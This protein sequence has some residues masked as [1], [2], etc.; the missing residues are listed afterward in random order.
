MATG[1]DRGATCSGRAA[2][3]GIDN[4]FETPVM[5]ETSEPGSVRAPG[6]RGTEIEVLVV[7]SGISGI[8]M[9]HK[10]RQ[11]GSN[12]VVFE[13]APGVGGT[14]FWNRYPGAQC[15]VPSMQY[16]YSFDEDL[17]QEWEWSE[18]HARQPEIEA[19]LNHVVDR[20]HLRD[21]IRFNT[22]ITKMTWDADGD[23]WVVETDGADVVRARRCVMA[24][25]GY[26]TSVVPDIPGL[27]RFSGEIYYTS[28]W[29]LHPV[30]FAGKR[31]GIIGTGASGVQTATTIAHESV[32]SLHVFQRSP[33][34]I[35]PSRDHKLDPT[36]VT[37]YKAT[38]AERRTRA[39]RTGYGTDVVAIPVGEGKTAEVPEAEFLRRAELVWERGGGA[40]GTVFPDFL[41]DAAA[42]NRVAEFLRSKVRAAV[43]DQALAAKLSA[44]DHYLG[45]KR[46]VIVDGYFEIFNRPNVALVDVKEQPI[47]E[48]TP[49]G[50]RT[51]ET[52]Y[53]LDVLILATGFDSGT[54]AMLAIDITGTAGR[55]LKDAWA[56]G[57]HTFL[58]IGV[59][60]FPNMYMINGAGSPGIRSHMM[61]QAEH[62]VDWIADFLG[63]Q[64][65]HAISRAEPTQEAAAQWTQHLLEVASATLLTIDDTQYVGSNIPGK[66][67]MTT[68]YLGGVGRY[69]DICDRVAASDYEGWMMRTPSGAVLENGRDWSGPEIVAPGANGDSGATPTANVI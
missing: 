63:Y 51:H 3:A 25:G 18:H 19:Y 42:N 49:A 50:V 1:H 66:P 40:M 33:S 44:R 11:M 15:D 38:Y 35:V 45:A 65:A 39:R 24:T 17:Q 55:T 29:P 10:L 59:P 14:W 67:R 20:L 28:H 5:P 46:I 60:G 36:Y 57:H 13:K 37:D 9:L 16:S 64:G 41:V 31:V 27:E 54:G 43:S 47:E 21:G 12:A 62:H 22:T 34:Y 26:H 69:R 58:G 8:Y 32:E 6:S 52:E 7:G 2:A 4:G 48:I 56:R 68:S 23:V 53:G 61:V 30:S